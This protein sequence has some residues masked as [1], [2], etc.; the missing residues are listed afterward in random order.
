MWVRLDMISR[1]GRRSWR[2]EGNGA[3]TQPQPVAISLR[4]DTDRNLGVDFGMAG[5]NGLGGACESRVT[6]RGARVT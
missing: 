1:A 4:P 2:T 6:A 5:R 3:L